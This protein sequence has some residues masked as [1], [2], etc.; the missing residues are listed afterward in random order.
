MTSHRMDHDALKRAVLAKKRQALLKAQ[1]ASNKV[2]IPQADRSQPLPLSPSQEALWFLAQ[3]SD[4][5]SAAYNMPTALR[6]QGT[7][8]VAALQ[9]TLDQLVARHESLRTCF[10]Q[11]GEQAYQHIHPCT[12]G[13]SLQHDDLQ[14]LGESD[15]RQRVEALYTHETETPFDLAN[16]PLIRG[17]LV[18]ISGTEHILILC[19]HH[20]ISDGWSIGI[21]FREFAALY[22]AE[23]THLAPTL[24]E[25][26]LHYADYAAWQH[27]RMQEKTFET[28]RTFWKETLAGAPALLELPLDYPRPAVQSFA[29]RTTSMHIDA[30]LTEALRALGQRHNA[31]LFMVLLTGWSTVLARLSGQNDIVIGTP[32]ANR[33]SASLEH[34]I[35]LFVNTLALRI[36]VDPDTSVADLLKHVRQHTL[37]AY[38]H[39][40]IPF[41]EVVS[42][43]QP[44]RS[45]G[46]SPIFQVAMALDNTP[47]QVFK[48]PGLDISVMPHTACNSRFDLT[49]NFE[50]AEDH[51]TGEFEYA[52]DLFTPETI[53]RIASCLTHVLRAMVNNDGS[54]VSQLPLMGVQAQHQLIEHFNH[55]QRDFPHDA[56]IQH[57]FEAQ[58]RRTPDATAIRFEDKTVGYGE[59]NQRANLLANHLISQGI[60]PDDRVAI[61]LARGINQIISM[62]ATLKAGGAYLI[63]DPNYPKARLDAMIKDAAPTA[64]ITDHAHEHLLGESEQHFTVRIDGDH[65][66][67]QLAHNPDANTLGLN[68]RHMAFVIYTSGSTGKPKG[69]ML[70]HRNVNRLIFNNGF[71]EITADD[72]VA[73]CANTA[74]DA[75]TW[76][77]WSA[78]L[79]GAELCV[80]PQQTLLSPERLC[81]VLI[82]QK[83]TA[84]WLTAGLFHEYL[85]ALMPAFKGM[86]Y[87]MAGGDVLEPSKVAQLRN[88]EYAPLHLINGY[89]PTEATTFS[90][91]Y[92]IPACINADRPVPIGRPIG[93][94]R[95]YLLDPHQQPV[96]I[97]V[98]GEIYISGPGVARGYLNQPEM[99]A[100]RFLPDPFVNTPDVQMYRTGDL[101]RWRANGTLDFVGRNDSQVK[102]RGFRIE[103]GEIETRLR[104]HPDVRD[105]VVVLREDTPGNKRLVAYL[106]VTSENAPEPAALRQHLL[107]HLS[108]YMI[109]SAFTVLDAFPLTANGKL[110]RR[111]LPMPD[112]HAVAARAYEAPQGDIEH[113]LADIW[114]SLLG[115][116]HVSRFDHFFD[117][118][119][120]SLVAVKMLSRARQHGI[121]ISLATLFS[122]PILSELAIAAH[123]SATSPASVLE[124]NPIPLRSNGT[125]PPLF[126]IHEPSGDPLVYAP[127][128]AQLPDD[129]PIYALQALGIHAEDEPPKT[130]EALASAHVEAIRRQQP[131]GPYRM[132][133]WSLGGIIAYEIAQQLHAAGE[134]VSFLGMIDS[135]AP[136]FSRRN[137]LDGTQSETQVRIETLCLFLRVIADMDQDVLDPLYDQPDFDSALQYCVEQH[138]LPEDVTKE[139]VR[140][141]LDTI[142]YMC[143][144]ILPYKDPTTHHNV[145]F[146]SAMPGEFA[147]DD[148]WHGLKNI[149]GPDSQR[150]IIGGT[151]E[152]I[153]KP[154]LLQ[155]MADIITDTLMPTVGDSPV[156][157]IKSGTPTPSANLF[158]VPGA[159]A[160]PFSLLELGMAFPENL[161]IYAFQARGLSD[162]HQ[163]PCLS[164]E[165]A[166]DI[167]LRAL[168]Q[169]QPHGPYHLL[170]HSFGGKIAFEMALRLQEQ[171]EEVVDLILVDARPPQQTGDAMPD[172]T[173]LETLEKLIELYNMRLDAPLSVTHDTLAPLSASEQLACL[174]HAL[175]ASNVLPKSSTQAQLE[176]IVR[177]MQANLSTGYIPKWHYKGKLHLIEAQARDNNASYS[178]GWEMYA[179]SVST[180]NT[181]GNHMTMLSSPN[182]AKWVTALLPHLSLV[183]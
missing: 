36:K 29:G 166:A 94:T 35:G 21:L 105:A 13:F 67:N 144:L 143:T 76:E 168:R 133:G 16:G 18:K 44:E 152:T 181:P 53:K 142:Y 78:L 169:Q 145:H 183:Q 90:T 58:A 30:T 101:A 1:S 77:I 111:A 113:L 51:I 82:E 109:P 156:V 68:A 6:L 139:E 66:A 79:N 37:E 135:F 146:F 33:N 91:T 71:A 62:L 178:T 147:I 23:I 74:F 128:A 157:T 86:R 24:P 11:R 125:Q 31:S 3:L 12:T 102:L 177:V 118:G 60:R 49:L 167:Y 10:I 22:K 92:D 63:L 83:V 55:T 130:L 127:F 52:T 9:K 75:A 2:T 182:V 162:L 154:P 17:R 88:S 95:V 164:V 129:L 46:H 115:I 100:E 25:L 132:A 96:P 50:E 65:Y 45:L 161:A 155:Y 138:W 124:A 170:G 84:M 122:H 80:I 171:G 107:Q 7:L 38:T 119:G 20:I 89:G 47:S 27:K 110:D 73:Q 158:C 123:A 104:Q 173:R 137:K 140:F 148:G 81:E 116:E 112:S 87:V 40:E 136:S 175:I 85:D 59:L 176:A 93:N 42:T 106:T 153:M 8:N 64:F 43:L 131:K 34:L 69:V 39:Q 5:A 97:G 141:R 56:L 54:M 103:L 180:T 61:C 57:L 28:Q 165:G 172:Y 72:R 159:G 126:L 19:Q 26:S 4:A 150:Y 32:T 41:D 108:D 98:I 149:V 99:T 174:H 120:H 160:T 15:Q 134:S 179:P 117:L 48:L 114:H 163:S 70:E 151:H 14:A 121:D